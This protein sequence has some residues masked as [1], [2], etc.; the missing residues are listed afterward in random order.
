MNLLIIL[1]ISPSDAAP[2]MLGEAWLQPGFSEV[3]RM[4]LLPRRSF[5][6]FGLLG[7]GGA[8]RRHTV[9]EVVGR[10]GNGKDVGQRQARVDHARI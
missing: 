5:V 8:I 6:V 9:L 4:G 1:A 7:A 2:V 3:N 10:R